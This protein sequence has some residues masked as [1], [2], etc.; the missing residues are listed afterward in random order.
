MVFLGNTQV[1]N[2]NKLRPVVGLGFPLQRSAGGYFRKEKNLSLIA[3]QIQQLLRT[4][5]GERVMRPNFGVKLKQFVFEQL[6]DTL[7]EQIRDSI[8]Y[9]IRN[10]T[11]DVKVNSLEVFQET[12][13]GFGDNQLNIRLKISW[14]FDPQRQEEIEVSIG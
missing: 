1:E 7:T 4:E 13:P 8:L 11:S 3:S 10:F 6:D 2:V 12:R 9:A 14:L 5:R